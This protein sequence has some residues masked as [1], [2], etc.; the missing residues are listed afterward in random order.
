MQLLGELCGFLLN[1]LFIGD[2]DLDFSLLRDSILSAQLSIC[3]P[4]VAKPLFTS[5]A[6]LLTF[7]EF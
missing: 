3:V 7:V 4:R 6:S 2:R 1:D 5:S